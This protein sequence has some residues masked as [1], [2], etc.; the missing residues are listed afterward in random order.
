MLV[1]NDVAAGRMESVEGLIPFLAIKL[2]ENA[3]TSLDNEA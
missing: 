2:D 3:F 1:H